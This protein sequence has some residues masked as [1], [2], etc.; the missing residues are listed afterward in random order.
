LSLSRKI[1]YARVTEFDVRAPRRNRV[2][3]DFRRVS[4]SFDDRFL[5]RDGWRLSRLRFPAEFAGPIT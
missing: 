5:D 3:L 4:N 1:D 2:K